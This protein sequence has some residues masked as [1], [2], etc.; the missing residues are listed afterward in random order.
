VS[1]PDRRVRLDRAHRSL[2]IRRQ[3]QLLG[4]ARSGMYRTP[5]PANDNDLTLM[6]QIDELFTA[7]PFLGSRRMA[8]MLQGDGPAVNRK[9]VQRLMRLMGIAA[10][11]PKPRTS[12]P[13]PGHR[14]FPYLLRGLRIDR[15]NQVWAADITYLPVGRGFLY[16]VAVMDW[17]SRAVLSWRLSNTMDVSFCVAALEEALARYGNP[18]IFNTDQGSQ[19]TS[20]AFTGAL[21]RTGIQISM[22]ERERWM[23]IPGEAAHH[24]GMMPPAIP[25]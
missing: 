9:R 4:V 5:T 23:L 16:L 13:A 12:K 22:D 10:V 14:I 20:A 17:A 3:C 11:G 2:S 1:L 15:P 25:R 18:E 8:R 24:S 6:R 21:E 7:W 19:F